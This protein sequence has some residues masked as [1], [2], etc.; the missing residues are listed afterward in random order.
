[1]EAMNVKT[2]VLPAVAELLAV[3]HCAETSVFELIV[4]ADA[5]SDL[6]ILIFVPVDPLLLVKILIVLSST[7]D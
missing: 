7:A 5:R 4:N 1:M 6:W 3:L 2:A